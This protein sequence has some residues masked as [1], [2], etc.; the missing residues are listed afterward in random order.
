[1]LMN[2][3]EAG[4]LTIVTDEVRTPD[5]DNPAG[6]FEH[7]RVKDLEKETDKSWVREAR[8]KVVK[9]ISHLLPSLPDD[10]FY[11]VILARRELTEVIVSLHGYT[12]RDARPV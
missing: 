12:I 4:G 9:V 8:G 6:Y 7:E 11:R 1:M 10:N 2:M 3:L 5:E